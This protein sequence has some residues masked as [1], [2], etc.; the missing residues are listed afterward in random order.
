MQRFPLRQSGKNPRQRQSSTRNFALVYLVS[1]HNTKH[2]HLYAQSLRPLPWDIRG[3]QPHPRLFAGV[4]SP[5]RSKAHR[6]D[7]G[8]Q[9]HASKET[10]RTSQPK[11]NS[12]ENVV[13]LRCSIW[14]KEEKRRKPEKIRPNLWVAAR[15]GSVGLG[16][17]GGEPPTVW[18]RHISHQSSCGVVPGCLA[19]GLGAGP[20]LEAA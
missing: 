10:R 1:N 11:E 12:S 6:L 20:D 15:W 16:W 3:E 2:A 14:R 13:C 18:L 7:R 5:F 17:A 8:P 4:R 19:C 9:A